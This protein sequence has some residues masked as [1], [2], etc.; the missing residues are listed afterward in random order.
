MKTFD[1]YT[2]TVK[3]VQQSK[4]THLHKMDKKHLT[5]VIALKRKTKTI[6]KI[7]KKR[8]ELTKY[9]DLK[10]TQFYRTQMLAITTTT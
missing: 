8:H 7:M 9:C 5:S 10:Y 3:V 1:I 2:F 6:L 4:Q